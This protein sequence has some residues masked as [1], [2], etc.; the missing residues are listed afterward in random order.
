MHCSSSVDDDYFPLLTT[1]YMA[2]DRMSNVKCQACNKALLP[3]EEQRA[4]TAAS[5]GKKKR[6]AKNMTH[7]RANCGHW[8]HYHCLDT[9]LTTPPFLHHCA[10]CQRQVGHPDWSDD[11][12][13]LERAWLLEQAK[14]R[15]LVSGCVVICCC[16]LMPRL[17]P[18]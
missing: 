13:Q 3:S 2:V 8:L 18:H 10:I 7:I 17:C 5:N 4:V 16:S 11:F 1:L 6:G 14:K 15:E 12:K 9:M